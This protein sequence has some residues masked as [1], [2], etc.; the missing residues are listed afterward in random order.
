MRN[1]HKNSKGPV[2]VRHTQLQVPMAIMS[3]ACEFVASTR[4]LYAGSYRKGVVIKVGPW[5]P[6]LPELRL[7]NRRGRPLLLA[8]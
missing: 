3:A 7:L 2:P 8:T 6:S 5:Y 4:G 1:V